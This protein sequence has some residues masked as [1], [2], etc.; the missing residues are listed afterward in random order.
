[1][2]SPDAIVR[3]IAFRFRKEGGAAFHA[4]LDLVRYFARAL[5]RARLPVRQTA[6]FHPHP[7]VVFPQAL[8]VGIP[9][10]HEWVEIEFHR[11]VRPAEAAAALDGALSPV[12]SLAEWRELPP[13]KKGLAP[14]SASYR[15]VG[16]RDPAALAEAASAFRSAETVS[17]LRER[18]GKQRTIDLRP[19]V[20]TLTACEG[21]LTFSVDLAAE[22][23]PRPDEIVRWIA[24]R[25][26]DAPADLTVVKTG[27]HLRGARGEAIESTVG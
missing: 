21:A 16:F 12:L 27:M 15:A 8:G 3:K 14:E 1:M 4:H 10:R 24:A 9:S 22:R 25:T 18:K 11:N 19:G 26:G 23:T 5:R 2:G 20:R 17:V 13:V 7:R 6:G